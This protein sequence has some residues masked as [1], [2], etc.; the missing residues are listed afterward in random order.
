MKIPTW[1]SLAVAVGCALMLIAGCG[2][3]DAPNVKQSR[4]IAA[5]NMELKKELDRSEARF[6][7]LKKQYDKELEKQ[8]KLLEECRQERDE[9][10][11]KSKQNIREQAKSLVEPLMEEITRLREE[12]RKLTAQLEELK[13]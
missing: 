7:N 4:T 5:E 2:E 6:E 13:K 10:K 3:K 11:A 9:W 12:N 8:R 1:K